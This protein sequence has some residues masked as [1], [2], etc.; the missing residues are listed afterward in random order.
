M[1]ITLSEKQLPVTYE[2]RCSMSTNFVI[3]QNY[4][5]DLDNLFLTTA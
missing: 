1:F 4:I 3:I 2:H 5:F